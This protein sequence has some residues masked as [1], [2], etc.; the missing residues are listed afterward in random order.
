MANSNSPFGLRPVRRIDGA[1]PNYQ[2]NPYQISTANTNKIGCGDIVK[3]DGSNAGFIDVAAAT[4]TPVLGVLSA[5]EWYDTAFKQKIFSPW[6]TGTTTAVAPITAYV[7]DDYNIVY[8]VQSGTG[9]PVTIASVRK[10]A[11]VLSTGVNAPNA[12]TGLSTEALDVASIATGQAA[13]P[14]KIVGLSQRVG[15]DNASNF[16]VVEVILNATNYKAGVA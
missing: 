5:C 2:T 7:Y 6:W 4:D 12:T 11:K 8:E 9:G 14:M 15:N 1:A 13:Y 10:N 3:F 16:N